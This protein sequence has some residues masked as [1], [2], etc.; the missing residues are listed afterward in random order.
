MA[1]GTL[2]IHTENLLPIIKKWLYSEKDIFTR[3]LI[4][5]SCDATSKLRHLRDLGEAQS[6]SSELR[7]DITID[8]ANKTLT[9][10]D[11]GIGMTHEEVETYIAQL[12]FSGA[13]EFLSKYKTGD[14]KEGIIGHFGLGFY[15]AYMV[16]QKVEIDTLSYKEGATPV[17]WSCDGSA[18]YEIGPGSR[19]ERGTTITLFLNPEE[20]EYLTD[21]HLKSI[22]KRFCS[23]LPYPIYLQGE[24]IN[25]NDPLW[26]KA[27]SACSD[28]EY[29]AFFHELY[30][31][32]PDPIFW[33]HLNIDYPFHLKG[34]L[35]FPKL[36]RKFDFN[37]SDIKLYS[38]R[39]FVSESCKDLI[40][41]YLIVLRGAIDSPDIPLNVSRSYLQIDKTVKQL[42]SHVSKK[43]ADRLLHLQTHEREKFLAAWPHIET[44]VKLGALQDTSFYS[45]VKPLLV[46]ETVSGNFITAEEYLE[47]HKEA[48][49]T[50]LFYT[51]DKT[52]SFLSLYTEKGIE[53]LIAAS[54][55]DTSLMHLLEQ[56]NHPAKFQRID[57][58]LSDAILDK[59]KEKTLLDAEGKT[60]AA[61]IAAFFRS[62]LSVSVDVEAKSLSSSSLPAFILIDE[63]SRRMKELLQLTEKTG[64]SP[65]DK[66]TFV[67]NTNSALVANLYNLKDSNPELAGEVI[68]H[69][70]DLSLLSQKEL[71]PEEIGRVVSHSTLVLEKLTQKK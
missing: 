51:T 50:K 23:F 48:Y 29:L 9:F 47:A 56:K 53:V 2:K 65:F 18:S 13:E 17:F 30:P 7:I 49:G 44:I 59:E 68:N 62:K 71:S 61:Q 14:E 1:Q 4:A 28:E 11:T 33:I 41:D 70:Y 16:A 37:R 45:R 25:P 36:H 6:D 19:T 57:G 21:T 38:Q 54:P 46:W 60:E 24:R 63:N 69:L 66:R 31:E 55:V 15:S 10:A 40:P 35:Y 5:N 3:E 52:S 64:P 43:V 32:E 34:I 67:I 12:A 58:G 27:P 8:K 26:S 22:L 39:V 42:A 20:E